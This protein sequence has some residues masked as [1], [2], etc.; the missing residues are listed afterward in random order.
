M[1]SLHYCTIILINIV[2]PKYQMHKKGTD[3][4]CVYSATECVNT[5]AIWGY[6]AALITDCNVY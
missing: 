2:S 6:D 3:A 1:A 4:Q 5:L